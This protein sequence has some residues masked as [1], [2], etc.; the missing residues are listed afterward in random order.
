MITFEPLWTTMEKKKVT[1]YALM[2]DHGI[3][4][5]LWYKLRHDKNVTL[6]TIN[7]LCEILECDVADIVKHIPDV[8]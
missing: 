4:H 6:E 2:N 3:S 8:K 5:S 1:G 7:R